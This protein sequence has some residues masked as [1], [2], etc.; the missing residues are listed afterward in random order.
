MVQHLSNALYMLFTFVFDVDKNVIEIQY[1]KNI[2]L[3]CQDLDD[4][5]LERSRCVGQ[6]KKYH[7]LL[8]MVIAGPEGRFLFIAFLNPHSIVGI[9]QIKLGETSSPT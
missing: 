1:Y 4:I 2:E 9:C 8:T 6:S 5:A 3:F 7:L